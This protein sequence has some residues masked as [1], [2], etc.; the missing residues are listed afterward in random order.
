[1][2]LLIGS[3]AMQLLALRNEF[4]TY[5]RRADAKIGLLKE[6]I[7]RVQKGEDVDVKGLLGTGNP[8]NE[9]EWEQVIKEIEEGDRLWQAN[10]RRRQKKAKRNESENPEDKR[11][12][13]KTFPFKGPET[14]EQIL[15]SENPSPPTANARPRGFY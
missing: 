15:R 10:A 5:S 9:K 8:E 1:M 14:K 11:A 3:N 13:E 7:E 12:S 6:V 4:T 2:S